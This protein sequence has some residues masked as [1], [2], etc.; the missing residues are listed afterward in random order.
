MIMLPCKLPGSSLLLPGAGVLIFAFAHSTAAFPPLREPAVP[1]QKKM[2]TWW[3][4]LEGSDAEASQAL[5]K[6]STWPKET[7]RFLKQKMQPLKITVEEV[8]AL[9][10]K[11]G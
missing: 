11:L 4:S 5:L 6:L 8:N 2:E 9:L 1:D 10:V 3:T 7:V